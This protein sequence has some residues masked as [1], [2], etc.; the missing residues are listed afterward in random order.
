MPLFSYAMMILK[1]EERE[2]EKEGR[3]LAVVLLNAMPKLV[4]HADKETLER[5]TNKV[6]RL[7]QQQ[8]FS[9]KV[10]DIMSFCIV[11]SSVYL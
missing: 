7:A 2:R 1:D 3:L 4:F 8:R 6:K 11:V 9:V 10:M 5:G